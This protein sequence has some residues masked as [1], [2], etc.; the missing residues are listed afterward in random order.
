MQ[1]LGASC[2]FLIF[3]FWMKKRRKKKRAAAMSASAGTSS[4]AAIHRL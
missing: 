1:D 3:D 2:K 4:H